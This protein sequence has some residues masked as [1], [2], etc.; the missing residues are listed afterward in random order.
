MTE[1]SRVFLGDIMVYDD[2]MVDPISTKYLTLKMVEKSCCLRLCSLLLRGRSI[3][4]RM[5]VISQ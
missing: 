2:P 4:N 5:E 3:K 1:C